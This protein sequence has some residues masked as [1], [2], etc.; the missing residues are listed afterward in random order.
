MYRG[1]NYNFV[2]E[3]NHETEC[4]PLAATICIAGEHWLVHFQGIDDEKEGM[5]EKKRRMNEIVCAMGACQCSPSGR[6]I[7]DSTTSVNFGGGM[8]C[9]APG[10]EGRIHFIVTKWSE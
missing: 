2:C 7:Y 5:D 4:A 8:Q 3:Y 6:I 10:S 9:C 1:A